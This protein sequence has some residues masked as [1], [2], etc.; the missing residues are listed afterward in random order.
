M[1]NFIRKHSKH[2]TGILRGFDR[3]LFRGT[4]RE[5]V[6]PAGFNLFLSLSLSNTSAAVAG[7]TLFKHSGHIP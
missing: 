4:L 1:Q 6:Y 5:M 3:M 7:S 2:I